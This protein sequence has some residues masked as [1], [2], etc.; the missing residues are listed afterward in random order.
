MS[1]GWLS[2]GANGEVALTDLNVDNGTLKVKVDNVNN[3][4]RVGINVGSELELPPGESSINEKVISIAQIG[5]TDTLPRTIDLGNIS[6]TALSIFNEL[7]VIP[8]IEGVTDKSANMVV[9]SVDTT[10]LSKG[11]SI[12]IGGVMNAPD[13][14]MLFTRLSGL[15]TGNETVVGGDFAVETLAPSFS[16]S[17]QSM[18]ER[19]R[20]TS[21]GNVGIGISNPINK[22]AVDGIIHVGAEDNTVQPSNAGIVNRG[23]RVDVPNAD[24]PSSNSTSRTNRIDT[25]V[26][27]TII[28]PSSGTRGYAIRIDSERHIETV[29]GLAAASATDLVFAA[30]EFQG[31]IPTVVDNQDSIIEPISGLPPNG[32]RTGDRANT[33]AGFVSQ[34]DALNDTVQFFT[35]FECINTSNLTQAQADV[36]ATSVTVGPGT[37]SGRRIYVTGF[38]EGKITNSTTFRIYNRASTTSR[39]DIAIGVRIGRRLGFVMV[40]DF[41][42]T[43][44]NVLFQQGD[45]QELTNTTNNYRVTP[46]TCKTYTQTNPQTQVVNQYLLVAGKFAST[47]ANNRLRLLNTNYLVSTTANVGSTITFPTASGDEED[48]YLARYIINQ[49]NGERLGPD[50]LNTVLGSGFESVTFGASII[51]VDEPNGE[52]Y[53]CGNTEKKGSTPPSTT[54][55]T[56]VGTSTSAWSQNVHTNIGSSTTSIGFIIK[57][58]SSTSGMPFGWITK[59]QSS[60][61]GSVTRIRSLVVNSEAGE[62]SSRNTFVYFIGTTSTTIVNNVRTPLSDLIFFNKN[63]VNTYTQIMRMNKTTITAEGYLFLAKYNSDGEYQWSTATSSGTKSVEGA[64]V[65]VDEKSTIYTGFEYVDDNFLQNDRTV[66]T[67]DVYQRSGRFQGI[68]TFTPNIK[69][70]TIRGTLSFVALVAYNP[71]GKVLFTSK[72]D[73]LGGERITAMDVFKGGQ[74]KHD[75]VLGITSFSE[76]FN[77]FD[78]SGISYKFV[79]NLPQQDLTKPAAFVVGLPTFHFYLIDP[80][81]NG[82]AHKITN[83]SDQRGFVIPYYER[84]DVERTF[85]DGIISIPERAVVEMTFISGGEDEGTWFITKDPDAGLIVVDKQNGGVGIGTTDPQ[86]LLHVEGSAFLKGNL[87]VDGRIVNPLINFGAEGEIGIGTMPGAGPRGFI[88]INKDPVGA[89][90][91]F[92]PSILLTGTSVN[93]MF[94]TLDFRNEAGVDEGFRFRHEFDGRLTLNLLRSG[95]DLIGPPIISITHGVNSNQ[96]IND[97]NAQVGFGTEFPQAK[98]H[99]EGSS[100][101]T[102]PVVNNTRKQLVVRAGEGITSEEL[103]N[104]VTGLQT[105]TAT[106]REFNSVRWFGGTANRYVAV[107]NSDR[108]DTSSDGKSWNQSTTVLPSKNWT[109]VAYAPSLNRYVAIASDITNSN[110]IVTSTT[111]G[112]SWT[113][114]SDPAWVNNPWVSITYSPELS[115]YVA[116]AFNPGNNNSSMYSSDGRNWIPGSLTNG[117]WISVTWGGPTG[118]GRFVVVGSLGIQSSTDGIAWTSHSTLS[119]GLQSVIWAPEANNG[120][121]R[122][123]AIGFVSGVNRNYFASSTNGTSWTITELP[124]T[125]NSS[126]FV[127]ISWGNNTLMAVGIINSDAPRCI[128]S[129]DEGSNWTT[130]AIGNNDWRSIAFGQIISF[131]TLLP[132]S[133]I[134]YNSFIAVAFS[135]TN[136]IHIRNSSDTGWATTAVG[137]AF[138]WMSLAHDPISKIWVAVANGGTGQRAAYSTSG[139]TWFIAS[140]GVPSQPWRSV[141]FGGGKFVAVAD[142]GATVMETTDGVSWSSFPISILKGSWQSIAWSPTLSRFI[143]VQ[144]GDSYLTSTNGTSWTLV[145]AAESNWTTGRNWRSIIW[146]PEANNGSG[147][148]LAVSATNRVVRSSNGTSWTTSTIDNRSWQSIAW[149]PTLKRFVVVADSSSPRVAYSTNDI[150]SSWTSGSAASGS[151][152]NSTGWRSV[153]WSDKYNIF[154]AV[155]SSGTNRMMTSPDGITWTS[156]NIGTLSLQSIAWSPENGNFVIVANSGSGRIRYSPDDF[157]ATVATVDGNLNVRN[158]VMESG[159]SLIPRGVIVAWTGS[160]APDGWAICDG[161]NGTPDLSGRFILGSGFADNLTPRTLNQ[162]GGAETHTLNVNE[163][164]EHDHY[165]A[166][167]AGYESNS[168]RRNIYADFS[169]WHHGRYRRDVRTGPTG[170]GDPH[171]NMPPFHV[172]AYIMKL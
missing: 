166:P 158:K 39:R 133:F 75:I 1:L 137:D 152:I 84:E 57:F 36:I 38:I 103:S 135:G 45:N 78:M 97:G 123:F 6:S 136:R 139:F 2:I 50:R 100:L 73:G 148:F 156:Y 143:A 99:V 18:F 134:V 3:V 53:L 76:Q 67:V 31:D 15:R 10:G 68:D 172:L 29:H 113:T 21:S 64:F 52:I 30:G 17:G 138:N 40:F 160:Q 112:T 5:K 151:D 117:P 81:D 159:F 106:D 96:T 167:S 71:D 74:E 22:L 91:A 153:T 4:R 49:T 86:E 41:N 108:I 12:G 122:F 34:I 79:S 16:G 147:L 55:T 92:K 47:V 124:S 59:L 150:G 56:H 95:A 105:A 128:R 37:G 23:K 131:T 110:T 9:S 90:I 27:S 72:I 88:H 43:F 121:G 129:I 32:F 169:G 104:Y 62:D 98:F 61:E 54:L 51:D 114:V 119:R 35:F 20:V 109:D 154:I 58:T 163:L 118:Q 13:S 168:S 87:I 77:C 25:T 14:Q 33:S 132:P 140:S 48:I 83:V 80:A 149:S 155:G 11:G 65:R 146:A 101:F 144:N 63:T 164:P 162:R 141:T 157:A 46:V 142:S 66:I 7:S 165:V 82:A 127:S 125:Y 94:G 120:N 161:D 44:Q 28:N 102:V 130:I 171:N 107:S 24:I 111:N 170:R 116:I 19:L 69:N 93:G 8:S 89:G 42:L 60:E 145:S 126:K 115:R 85:T 26:S 70:N